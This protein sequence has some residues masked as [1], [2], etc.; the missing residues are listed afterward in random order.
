MQDTVSAA[1]LPEALSSIILASPT[2]ADDREQMATIR[3][4][5]GAVVMLSSVLRRQ[6]IST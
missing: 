3:K 1:S 2:V 6:P 5:H 4:F